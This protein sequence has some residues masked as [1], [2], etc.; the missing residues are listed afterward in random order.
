MRRLLPAALAIALLVAVVSLSAGCSAARRVRDRI[1]GGG[2]TP[3]PTRTPTDTPTATATP[4]PLPTPTPALPPNPQGLRRWDTLPVPYCIT[5]EGEGYVSHELFITAVRR[6]LDAWGVP[7]LNTGE[8]GPPAQDDRVN[9][10]GWGVLG[11]RRGRVYEAGLTQ[12]ITSECTANCDANDRIR[13][14][15]ADITI[16]SEPPREFRSATCLYSTL[17]HE[18]GHFLGLDH[19]PSPAVMQAETSLCLTALTDADREA[20]LSRYGARANPQ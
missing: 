17:L 16:D 18:T 8:C 15:E 12:T 1:T 9:E 2:G 4:T 20:L 3:T 6:A 5:A 11:S 13:L 19:L 14:V 10:I 7:T